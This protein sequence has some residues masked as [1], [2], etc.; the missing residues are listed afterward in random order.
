MDQGTPR[1][2]QNS[3][4]NFTALSVEDFEKKLAQ[5][6]SRYRIPPSKSVEVRYIGHFDTSLIIGQVLGYGLFF[7]VIYFLMRGAMGVI[8]FL[9]RFMILLGNERR[10]FF[11]GQHCTACEDTKSK[12][13]F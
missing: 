9:K 6:Q 1:N 8:F 7:V 3:D 5:A 2:K 4:Y 13:N 10:T 12:S 11:N